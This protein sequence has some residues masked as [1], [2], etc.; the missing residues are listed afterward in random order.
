M[1]ESDIVRLTGGENLLTF[2][3][4]FLYVLFC[5]VAQKEG[6][7]SESH[8]K[9]V[10]KLGF[11]STS[12]DAEHMLLNHQILIK[13]FVRIAWMSKHELIIVH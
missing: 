2:F 4:L 13:D 7:L 6:Q 9:N 12:F 10:M 1:L 11:E 8:V 3:T 5:N